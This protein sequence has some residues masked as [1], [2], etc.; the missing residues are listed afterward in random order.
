MLE[1]VLQAGVV[2]PCLV[3]FNLGVIAMRGLDFEAARGRF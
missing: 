3:H 2:C 1:Q